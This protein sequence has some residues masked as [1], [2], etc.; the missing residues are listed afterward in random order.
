MFSISILFLTVYNTYRGQLDVFALAFVNYV[1]SNWCNV[2]NR[3]RK[4]FYISIMVSTP[5]SLI[6][7]QIDYAVRFHPEF[8]LTDGEGVERLWSFIRRFT[9]ITKEM[10]PSHRIDLLTDGL[11][12]YGRRKNANIGKKYFIKT[13]HSDPRGMEMW[14]SY[15]TIFCLILPLDVTTPRDSFRLFAWNYREL[16]NT[17]LTLL[18]TGL[19]RSSNPPPL[20]QVLSDLT[21]RPSL[22]IWF[23]PE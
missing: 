22:L 19:D 18:A 14:W 6:I 7:L 1:F 3:K 21:T 4:H 5:S 11:I 8:G 20:E 2:C 15:R 9:A 17:L 16:A 12:H 13:R 10:T 23:T